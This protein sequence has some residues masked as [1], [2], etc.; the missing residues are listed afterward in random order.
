MIRLLA[1]E[2]TLCYR[3]APILIILIIIA[4]TIDHR[5]R[6]YNNENDE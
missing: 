5:N 3:F 1:R 4:R 6:S 2:S